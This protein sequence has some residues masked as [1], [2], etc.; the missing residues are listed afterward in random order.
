M[1]IGTTNKKKGSGREAILSHSNHSPFCFA[2]RVENVCVNARLPAT[3]T[4]F[5]YKKTII[6]V[7]NRSV[8]TFT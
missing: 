4:S 1:D 8:I 5:L 6:S 3:S 2:K 7:S